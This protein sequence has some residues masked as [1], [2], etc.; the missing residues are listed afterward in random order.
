[1]RGPLDLRRVRTAERE[2]A[3][4]VA[5]AAAEH[6]VVDLLHDQWRDERD[7]AGRVEQVE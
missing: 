7:V 1:L 6:A 5:E 4:G 2:L 3:K